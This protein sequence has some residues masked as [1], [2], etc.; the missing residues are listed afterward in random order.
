MMG[1]HVKKVTNC[2][3]IK[4]R[5]LWFVA[6]R[7]P[8]FRPVRKMIRTRDNHR[9]S[10]WLIC[11]WRLRTIEKRYGTEK[12]QSI[13]KCRWT[14]IKWTEYISWYQIK[15]NPISGEFVSNCEGK[16]AKGETN[17]FSLLWSNCNYKSTFFGNGKLT[18][19][20]PMGTSIIDRHNQNINISTSCHIYFI[21]MLSM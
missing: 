13:C 9:R 21:Q 6:V 8:I 3:T 11:V 4:S 19:K 17:T 5:H 2:Y 20:N 18:L 12:M 14:I 7:Q 16:M 15:I 10:L 1:V